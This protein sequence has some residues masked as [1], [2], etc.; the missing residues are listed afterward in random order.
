MP[1]RAKYWL[2][3]LF[4]A[5]GIAN[6]AETPIPPSPTRWVTDAAGFM[7]EN[8]V[9]TLDA[10]VGAYARSSGHQ[11]IVYVG[12][13]TGGTPIEDWAVRAFK[14]W[15]VG[16]KGLDDGLA[17]FIFSD[18]HQLRIE[19]G[20]GLEGQVPDAI[21]SRIINQVIVPRIQSGDRDGAVVAGV[22]AIVSVISGKGLAGLTA[23]PQGGAPYGR[24]P[25]T[26][27]QMILFGIIG[28]LILIFLI[29]HPTLAF[30]LF[31]T[32]LSGGRGGGFGGGDGG[33]SGGGGFGGGGGSS[34]GGGASG[35]W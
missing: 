26:L 25:M 3:I 33:D 24:K 6:A 9:R 13:T 31:V 34:G 22:D 30:F 21:A 15:K 29:T 23:R 27:G 32:M 14:A 4:L 19:V 1:T 20:Y 2:L 7:S 12:K 16:K 5:V 11:I 28:I 18:D 35:S 8:A 17:L 10:Q